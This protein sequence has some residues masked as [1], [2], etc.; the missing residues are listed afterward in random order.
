[1]LGELL[2]QPWQGPALSE[3]SVWDDLDGNVPESAADDLTTDPFCPPTTGG[4][5]DGG[6]R[7]YS[8]Y[9]NDTATCRAVGRMR[10]AQRAQ[11]CYLSAAERLSACLSGKPLPPLNIWNI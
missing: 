8:N 5:N 10:G 11:A 7:C 9:E 4:G 6:S 2:S 1:M 3:G